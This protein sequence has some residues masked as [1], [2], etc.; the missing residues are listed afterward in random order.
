M[1][2]VQSQLTVV[3]SG[4]TRRPP[5]MS[6]TE[7]I[8]PRPPEERCVAR[9]GSES[10]YSDSI[11]P[12]SYSST[13]SDPLGWKMDAKL[14]AQQ[15]EDLSTLIK[16]GALDAG[17]YTAP[18]IRCYPDITACSEYGDFS[19]DDHVLSNVTY[20]RHQSESFYC[21]R[22]EDTG[23]WLGLIQIHESRTSRE[24]V[25]DYAPRL[26]HGDDCGCYWS[27]YH[28]SETIQEFGG[29]LGTIGLPE[30]LC[31]FTEWLV[32]EGVISEDYSLLLAGKLFMG[33]ALPLE[34]RYYADLDEYYEDHN[35]AVDVSV[36]DEDWHHGRGMRRVWA[37]F[38][39]SWLVP[40]RDDGHKS[41]TMDVEEQCTA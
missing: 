34:L 38:G 14:K 18:I 19:M 10:D 22:R 31:W 16:M 23:C 27:D 8:S 17:H 13:D 21:F 12:A 33:A 9:S 39:D 20:R 36:N 32:D 24:T 1:G 3:Y 29:T 28:H 41:D 40:I 26:T 15:A 7:V 35:Q 6:T 2:C 25:E 30:K 5:A 11:Y 37:G 4:Q